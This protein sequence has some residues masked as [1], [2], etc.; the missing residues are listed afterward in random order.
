MNKVKKEGGLKYVIFGAGE[1]GRR[2]LR[3][4]QGQVAFFIDNDEKRQGTFIDGLLIQSLTASESEIKEKSYTVI[5]ANKYYGK[6]IEKQI[7]DF[8]ITDYFYY[9]RT[10]KIY[11]GTDELI[12]NPYLFSE[13][14]NTSEEDWNAGVAGNSLRKKINERAA[15]LH[16]NKIMFEHVEIE[17]VNRCNGSCSFCPISKNRDTREYCEMT[18]E[19][20]EDIIGQLADMNYSGRLA[21][22]S[23]NEPFLDA[24]IL[25]RHKFAREMLPKARMHLFTNG[26]L[27]TLETFLEIMK[28]LDELVIDNYQQDLNLITPCREI[29]KYC[30]THPE[31]VEKVTIVLRKQ[32]E[33]LTSRG[34]DAPNRKDFV[35]YGTDRCILPYTQLVIRPDGKVSLCCNDPMGK[36]TLGDLTKDRIIDVWNNDRFRMVREYIYQ[37]RKNWKHCEYCDTFNLL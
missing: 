30:K 14:Q 27:L 17:T 19:L 24:K 18:D 7:T 15:E 35:S 36:N 22:F 12:Y 5:I 10:G 34:G 20:F 2:V 21:L 6:E 31:L 16:E 25:Q 4:Y 23:N 33:I 3:Q 32:D 9:L 29:E 37:G 28:Y 26:T 13:S 8:G 1:V 11:G